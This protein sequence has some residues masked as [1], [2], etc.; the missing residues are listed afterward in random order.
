MRYTNLFRGLSLLITT[1]IVKKYSLD[2]FYYGILNEACQELFGLLDLEYISSLFSVI[3]IRLLIISII[4]IGISIYVINMLH[5]RNSYYN[6]LKLKSKDK[7]PSV[8]IFDI[9]KLEIIYEYILSNPLFFSHIKKLNIGS[10]SINR[11]TMIKDRDVYSQLLFS[12]KNKQLPPNGEIIEFNDDKY[13]CS[14]KIYWK[15]D[16]TKINKD[17]NGT[18]YTDYIVVPYCTID[19]DCKSSQEILKY[20]NFI[21]SEIQKDKILIERYYVKILANSRGDLINNTQCIYKGNIPNYENLKKTYIDTFFHEKKTQLWEFI[22]G[23]HFEPEK[24]FIRGQ[25]PRCGIIAYGPPGTGKSSFAYRIAK[26]L[27]RHIV[28]IDINSIKSRINLYEII[29][30]PIINGCEKTSKEVV[31]IF[32]EFDLVLKKLVNKQNNSTY[33]I[34][35]DYKTEKTEK[36]DL[37]TNSVDEFNSNNE[38]GS[39]DN[40]SNQSNQISQISSYDTSNSEEI[41][42]QDILEI[43]QGPVPIEGM[44][45][46][47]TTNNLEAI[48]EL[49][50][51][52]VR[53]GRLTPVYFGNPTCDILNEISMFYY[54]KS[55]NFEFDGRISESTTSIIEL[56][57]QNS[58]FEIFKTEIIKLLR[59]EDKI[60]NFM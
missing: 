54:S 20:I 17:F 59:K 19:M 21:K 16:I 1:Q 26:S 34:I 37:F 24:F 46:I 22:R 18:K 11:S 40:Q 6:S 31:F 48:K 55:L 5:I 35:T 45:A 32:D 33:P 28:S 57:L 36:T 4:I 13:K 50:P 2:T 42:I 60:I 15:E 14:G 58:N 47:A 39:K 27:N 10:L 44:I 9:N 53:N 51:A 8:N 25:S 12:I 52:I 41:T 30:N 23:I 3:D 38:N 7:K 56:T 49:N 29:K 43:L